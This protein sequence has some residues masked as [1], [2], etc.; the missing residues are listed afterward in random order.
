[1]IIC[2]ILSDN[3]HRTYPRI[4]KPLFYIQKPKVFEYK[5]VKFPNFRIN[6]QALF[7]SSPGAAKGQVMF[8]A[9]Q[10][11]FCNFYAG[12]GICGW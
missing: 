2:G 10:H 11:K 5:K 7:Y 4:R 9:S 8:V 12:V 3:S 6:T 1:M